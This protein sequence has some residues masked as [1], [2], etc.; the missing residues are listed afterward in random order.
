MGVP[1]FR[2]VQTR[3]VDVPSVVLD[4]EAVERFAGRNVLRIDDVREML[5]LDDSRIDRRQ[6]AGAEAFDQFLR[7]SSRFVVGDVAEVGERHIDRKTNGHGRTTGPHAR[8][9]AHRDLL[10]V[11]SVLLARPDRHHAGRE[12]RSLAR[13][14][15]GGLEE[16][17]PTVT[18]SIR[19]GGRVKKSQ[20]GIEPRL[21]QSDLT[22]VA[23]ERVDRGEGVGQ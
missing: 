14:R 19:I 1:N 16:L 22:K 18:Q 10:E 4:R 17:H 21:A 11:E 8:I 6:G 12:V 23:L 15:G 20:G 9:P 13:D 3:F 7:F 5:G 2:L